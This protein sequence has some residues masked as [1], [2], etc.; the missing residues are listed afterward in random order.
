MKLTPAQERHLFLT[1]RISRRAKTLSAL[2]AE[3]MKNPA[4]DV[5][6]EVVEFEDD[7]I[8]FLQLT[9]R[10]DVILGCHMEDLVDD[11]RAVFAEHR[12]HR[13]DVWSKTNKVFGV[14]EHK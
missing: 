13:Q 14:T 4:D 1:S 8:E 7:L 10:M 12:A 2:S 3:D 5:S 9:G 11:V 6:F